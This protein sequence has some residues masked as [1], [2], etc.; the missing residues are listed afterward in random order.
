VSFTRHPTS[1]E[2]YVSS[3]ISLTLNANLQ[4]T[5][6]LLRY[7]KA[8]LPSDVAGI[9]LRATNDERGTVA[10]LAS[11]SQELDEEYADGASCL[12]L[13]HDHRYDH[14]LHDRDHAIRA[15]STTP[16]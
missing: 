8:S 10:G 5:Y 4:Q 11:L 12:S 9:M 1:V 3:H 2:S 16:E 6:S 14:L 7:P 13:M 15:Q